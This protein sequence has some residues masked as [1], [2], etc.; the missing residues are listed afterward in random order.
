MKQQS[1]NELQDALY[2]SYKVY[3]LVFILACIGF[4]LSGIHTVPEGKIGYIQRLGKWS[5]QQN[6][7]GIHF[8][9]PFFIDR[10]FIFDT[11]SLHTLDINTFTA[12]DTQD[13]QT[14]STQVLITKDQNFIHCKW[15]ITLSLTNPIEKFK[16]SGSES[17]NED[18]PMLQHLFES[19]CLRTTAEMHID[20]VLKSNEEYRKRILLEANTKLAQLKTG[21]TITRTDLIS[22]NLP[23]QVQEA[24][25]EVQKQ[26]ALKEQTLTKAKTYQLKL[27]QE[28]SSMVTTKLEEA[29]TQASI[30]KADLQAEALNMNAILEKYPK[31]LH[32]VILNYKLQNTLTQ[33]LKKRKDQTF[34]IQKDSELRLNIAEDPMVDKLQQNNSKESH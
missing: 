30:L 1:L 9:Y 12:P 34:V 2:K 13:R 28:V 31:N 18:L 19:I 26:K 6:K 29:K 24:F 11:S 15:S 14:A 23:Q 7:P 33:A 5:E 3:K 20:Q 4:I 8:A 10:V 21:Y 27:E 25:N 17:V 16:L 22:V 32:G